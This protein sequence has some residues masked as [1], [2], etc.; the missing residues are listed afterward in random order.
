[1]DFE[2]WLHRMWYGGSRW[3]VLLMPLSWLF[4]LVLIVRTAMYHMGIVRI[5]NVGVPVVV[6]GN[7]TAGGTGKTPVSVW[8]AQTLID[9]GL[10]PGIISRGYGGNTGPDPVLVTASSDPAIVGDEALLMATRCDCP[11]VVHPDRVRAARTAIEAGASV[12]IADDGLQHYRL[13]RDFEIALV[14]GARA[15]G[16]GQM[17]PAGPLREPIS[18]LELV[19]EVLLQNAPG[20]SPNRFGK[21]ND[22]LVTSNFTLVAAPFR[23]LNDDSE[24]PI[25]EFSG[26]R[27]HAI[28][29]ISNPQR[30]FQLLESHNI[31]VIGHP[32]GDHA[33]ISEA[34]T[35]F[36]DDLPV[37]MTEKDAVKCSKFARE[38]L[39]YLPVDVKFAA[40]SNLD[41][42]EELLRQIEGHKS[43]AAR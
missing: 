19:D 42:V 16:N 17:L 20:G 31:N 23:A 8:L 12:L 22:D 11:V 38:G 37:V 35:K 4:S 29:A 24:T 14:D 25:V 6:V 41:W 43:E 9:N 40:T 33:P 10:K 2:S 7:I 13:H 30:F 26:K 1:M 34:D 36:D 5:H 3:F 32:L 27:V 39:W 18:R 21:R 28:A 15:F